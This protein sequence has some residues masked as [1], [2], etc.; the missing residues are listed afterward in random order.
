MAPSPATLGTLNAVALA[1]GS[2]IRA[3]APALFASLF[4]TSVR[5]HLLGGQL[6]WVVLG[7]LA[8]IM[9]AVLRW[10]PKKA[11][12]LAKLSDDEEEGA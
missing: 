5:L 8:V 2:G 6:I 3:F 9:V 11:E 10:L 4:A 7:I 12:G 1:V